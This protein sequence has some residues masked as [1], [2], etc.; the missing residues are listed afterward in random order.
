MPLPTITYGETQVDFSKLPETS[1]RAMLSRGLT[2]FLGSEQASKVIAKFKAEDGTKSG[3][4]VDWAAAKAEFV[5]AALVALHDGTVG[6]ST[7]GPTKDPLEAEIASIVKR[8]V[9]ATLKANGLKFP[10]DGETVTFGNG[11][12]RTGA[13]MLANYLAKNSDAVHKE[14]EKALADK[15]RAAKKL[16]DK[17]SEKLGDL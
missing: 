14:A 9:T 6:V 1:V 3:T 10:K 17:V 11:V 2:H 15:A 4:E 7:R 16:A 12:T 5:A 8:E 13:E